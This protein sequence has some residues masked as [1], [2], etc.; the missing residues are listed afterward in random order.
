MEDNM[1]IPKTSTKKWT[2]VLIKKLTNFARKSPIMMS[3][4]VTIHDGREGVMVTHENSSTKYFFPIDI[5]V[6]VK[7]FI[8]NI[9]KKLVAN[10]Y[11]RLIKEEFSSRKL[12]AEEIALKLEKGADIN[13]V[14]QFELEKT[15]EEMYLIDKILSWKDVVILKL[16]SSTKNPEDIGKSF[17]YKY[18][19][20]IVLYL[21]K[22]R[23][24]R[25][26]LEMISNEF[27]QNSILVRCIEDTS[28]N[29]EE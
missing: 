1:L 9:K 7:D 16:E 6:Q 18:N 10:H 17:Q 2:E 27:W 4:L 28:V 29:I 23:S 14:E 11:P 22:Y 15:N 19:G 20:S 21:K 26:S 13:S 8:S 5:D 24:G 12:T 25:H 3:F